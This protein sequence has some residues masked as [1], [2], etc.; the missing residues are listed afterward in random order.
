MPFSSFEQIYIPEIVPDFVRVLSF[1]AEAGSEIVICNMIRNPDT[2]AKFQA[3]TE[4]FGL[5]VKE[6]DQEGITKSLEYDRDGLVLLRVS[7]ATL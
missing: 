6:I 2:Y 1:F 5:V 3:E 4:R 7:R